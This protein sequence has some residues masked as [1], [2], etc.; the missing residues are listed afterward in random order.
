MAMKNLKN[1][2]LIGDYTF[3]S[4]GN[5]KEFKYNNI[6]VRIPSWV[7]YKMNGELL[8]GKGIKP[9]VLIKAE[10]SITNN[11]DLVLEKAIEIL[12]HEPFTRID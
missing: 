9:D 5:P 6:I 2:I 10:E 4:S 11:K 7:V 3:G 12:L 1:S 8:E